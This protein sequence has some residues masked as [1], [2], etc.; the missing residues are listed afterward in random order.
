MFFFSSSKGFFIIQFKN[1]V[2][3]ISF[4]SCFFII[5]GTDWKY[6]FMPHEVYES[7]A[8]SESP[9]AV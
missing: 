7:L 6:I 5:K 8:F 9:D 4:F 3:E 2:L 1:S